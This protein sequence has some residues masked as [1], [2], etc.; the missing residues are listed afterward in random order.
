MNERQRAYYKKWYE[1]HKLY[2]SLS[3]GRLD[4]L[5]LVALRALKKYCFIDLKL[6]ISETDIN[7]ANRKK[8]KAWEKCMLEAYHEEQNLNL[9]E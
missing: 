4:Y 8:R 9:K 1:Q 5:P 2:L 3:H 6:D 7:K